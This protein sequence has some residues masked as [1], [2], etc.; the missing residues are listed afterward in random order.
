MSTLGTPRVNLYQHETIREKPV[1]VTPVTPDIS[2]FRITEPPAVNFSAVLVSGEGYFRGLYC[3]ITATGTV[4]NSVTFYDTSGSIDLSN[5]R[6]I[7]GFLL[8]STLP[9]HDIVIPDPGIP[10]QH[11]IAVNCSDLGGGGSLTHLQS[12]IL[13]TL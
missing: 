7:F 2:N 12:N 5:D 11:G 3:D 13:Y 1:Y 9:Q 10:F 6:Q 8:N 4:V